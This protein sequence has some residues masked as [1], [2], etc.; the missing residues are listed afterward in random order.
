MNEGKKYLG[1]GSKARQREDTEDRNIPFSNALRQ[2]GIPATDVDYVV[3]NG[4]DDIKLIIETTRP[5]VEVFSSVNYLASIDE[6]RRNRSAGNHND[7]I[8][9]N[10]ANKLKVPA[11]LVVFEPNVGEEDARIWWR[12]M[13]SVKWKCLSAKDFFLKVKKYA[14]NEHRLER[15]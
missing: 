8:I 13:D 2:Y 10:I 15:V 4:Q 3:T 9:S 12:H 14:L 1:S 6:R 5:D 11:I 7:E